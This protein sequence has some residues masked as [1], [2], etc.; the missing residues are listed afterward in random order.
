MFDIELHEPQNFSKYRQIELDSA[1]ISVYQPLADSPFFSKRYLM[2]RFL[3]MDED[4][5]A[6]NEKLWYEENSE[7]VKNKT[8]KQQA[9][10]TDSTGLGDVGI[11]SE[12]EGGNMDI[13]IGD[14][15]FD[16]ESPEL[17]GETS[18]IGGNNEQPTEEPSEEK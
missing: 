12:P 11:R 6:E 2:K 10:E 15:N 3:G 13:D 18:P 16:N 5:I 1:Q 17:G 8:G 14:D 7:I 9:G 4:E